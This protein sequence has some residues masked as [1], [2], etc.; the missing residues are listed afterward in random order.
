MKISELSVRKPVTTGMMYVLLC[1][2]SV[3]FLPRLGVALYPAATMPVLSVFT[4]WPDVGPEEIE[5]G[6]TR[7]LESRLSVVSGLQ[8]MTSSSSSGRSYIRLTFGY[9]V[10]LD[11]ASDDVREVLTRAVSALPDGCEAPSFRRFDM[12]ARPIMRLTVSGDLP[13]SELKALAEDAISPLLER[14]PGVASAEVSGGASKTVRVDVD[15]NRLSAFG[16]SL[17]A[18]SSALSSRNVRSSGGTLVEGGV[19]YELYVDEGYS[20]L[21]DIRQTV[22]ST[23]NVPGMG[24]SVTRSNVVK[25]EDVASVYETNDYTGSRVYIDGV[26]GLYVSI[27]NETDS[28]STN[29]SAEVRAAI[30]AI[31][32]GL[33]SGVILTVASDETTMISSTMSEV[34]SSAYQGGFLAM[35]VILLFLRSFKGTVVIALSMPISILATLLGMALFGLTLNIM[36]M[37]GLILGIGMIVDSSIVILDNIHRHREAGN[38]SAA[39]A[40]MGSSEVVV[41]ITAST[42]T[43]LCVFLPVLIYKAELEM[44]GQMFS[45]M[46]VTV[47]ISLTVSLIVAVT[48]VPALCGSILRIDTRAQS[49]IRSKVLSLLDRQ[50]ERAI[51]FAEDAYARAIGF[52]LRNKFPVLALVCILTALSFVRFASL[53]V[54]LSPESR[55]DDIVTITMTLPVGTNREVTEDTLFR[56]QD[57]IREKVSGY[58]S[59]IITAGREHSGN[60]Q[61][62]LPPVGEQKVTPV[63]IREKVQ[64]DLEAIP[65]AVFTYSAGRRFGRGS[66]VDV[67][68][69][70]DD[71]AAVM[72]VSAKIVET[73]KARVPQVTDVTSDFERGR[74]QYTMVIDHDRASAL[75]VTVSSIAR[76]VRAALNGVTGTYWQAGN[77]EIPIEVRLPDSNVATLADIG[78]FSVMGKNGRVS[79]DNLVS[80]RVSVAP[81][82]ITREEGVRVNHVTANLQTGLAASIVQPLVEEAIANHVVIPPSV[83]LSFAGE[84]RDLGSSGRV[85]LMVILVAVFLVFIVMAAQFESLIDPLIIFFSIPLLAI[86]VV[87]VYGV[88]G[89][90]FSLFSAVGVVALVGIIVNNGIVLVDYANAL[91][92][93]K[94]P[95]LEA[96]VIAGRNRLRPILMTTLTTVIAAVPMAFFPGEGGEMMQPIGVTLVGGLVSGSIM[97]LFVTPILYSLFNKRREKTFEDPESL[98]N[99]LVDYDRR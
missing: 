11:E 27:T 10:D 45:D 94:T 32:E 20:S 57:V 77:D 61:I 67:R 97:T 50:I 16:L 46:V 73:L 64:S 3:I 52:S 65:D 26:P 87:S 41:A 22:V 54:S 70:S 58:R 8:E 79:L 82:T 39:A 76:E 83:K 74:P 14:V 78:R 51:V 59:L 81:T 89:Q 7:P 90:P 5:K 30:P 99:M 34:Y 2:V 69:S 80:F 49:P 66:P 40:I 63:M 48:L 43:T 23:I 24:S 12:N 84:A 6:V 38:N 71:S 4:S 1:A 9:D 36:T 75:G 28:N 44:L 47:V 72:E 68:L 95:V 55:A 91:V 86:G 93:R 92:R 19:D 53:G 85:M 15:E 21:E 13:I 31:N 60:I 98:E 88:S 29:V 35:V 96:C 62:S 25:L 17:T 33:P 37:T 56:V 42:L 18:V